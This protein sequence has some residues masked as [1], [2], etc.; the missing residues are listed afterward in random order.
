MLVKCAGCDNYSRDIVL[1]DHAKVS[2]NSSKYCSDECGQRSN[3]LNVHNIIKSMDN[4]KTQN[5]FHTVSNSKYESLQDPYNYDELL[6][7]MEQLMFKKQKMKQEIQKFEEKLLMIDEI[8][9]KVHQTNL[10]KPAADMICGFDYSIIKGD[11]VIH[12]ET[13]EIPKYNSDS[14]IEHDDA[15]SEQIVSDDRKDVLE[16]ELYNYSK[17]CEIIGKCWKHS[18]WQKLKTLEVEIHIEELVFNKD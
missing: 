17:V 9:D 16:N 8:V 1:P 2:L 12:E 18:G 3:L 11:L 6:N 13:I 15:G 4:V 7:E 5:Y 14:V 10:N